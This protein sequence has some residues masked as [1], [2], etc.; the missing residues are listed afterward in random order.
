MNERTFTNNEE[1]DENKRHQ[2]LPIRSTIAKEIFEAE[3]R[4]NVKVV[5]IAFRQKDSGKPDYNVE[6]II[7]DGGSYEWCYVWFNISNRYGI[8]Y[9]ISYKYSYLCNNY[10]LEENIMLLCRWC[11]R[12]IANAGNPQ[13]IYSDCNDC[14]NSHNKRKEQYGRVGK[15]P[16][17]REI[18]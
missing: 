8:K 1:I 11:K 4:F 9:D 3:A 17:K 15:I 13:I 10:N 5:A 2:I 12:T 14:R 16:K 6:L 7:D 18:K